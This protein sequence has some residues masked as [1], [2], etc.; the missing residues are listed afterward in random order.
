VL[1]EVPTRDFAEALEGER[2][3]GALAQPIEPV[4]VGLQDPD[5]FTPLVLGQ[6]NAP[7]GEEPSMRL[8]LRRFAVEDRA[9]EVEDDSKAGFGDWPLGSRAWPSSL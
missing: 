7:V 1:L 9:V 4:R 5:A 8:E 2:M 6:R 3:L